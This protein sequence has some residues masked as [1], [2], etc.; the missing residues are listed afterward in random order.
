D[1]DARSDLY[2]LGATAYF[3]LSGHPPFAGRTVLDILFAHRKAPVPHLHVA[4][5]P[6]ALEQIIRRCL[7]KQ[8]AERFASAEELA[9]AL[10]DCELGEE[11]TET[12]ARAWWKKAGV[13]S[14]A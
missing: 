6:A 2:S 11:W 8:P 7:A 13:G 14:V 9:N 1:L 3:M 4:G 5:V 12:E 10:A